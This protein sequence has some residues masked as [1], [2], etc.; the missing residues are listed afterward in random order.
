MAIGSVILIIVILVQI[1]KVSELAAKIRGEEESRIRSNRLNAAGMLAFVVVFLVGTVISAWAYRNWMLGYG[2]LESASEHGGLLDDLFSTTL[3]FTGIVFVLTHI[4][5]FYFAYK[6]REKKGRKVLFLPHDNRVEVIWTIIPAVVMCFLVVQGLVAWNT[7]MADVTD[8]V[9]DPVTNEIVQEG[10][11][12][13]EDYIEIE[14]TGYQFA[15][16]LRYPGNDNL[17][18]TSNFRLIDVANN[19]IGQDWTDPKGLDDFYPNEI[20]LPKGKKVRVRIKARDVLHNFYLPHFRVKMDAIPGLPT[21]FVFTPKY[22]TEEYR[23][24]LA[25]RDRND[26]VIYPEYWEFTDPDAPEDGMLWE[27]F[28]FELACAELCG[29]GHFSMHK[30]V[31]IV[32]EDEYEEWLATQKSHYIGSIR[33][34]DADPLKGQLLDYE[35][36]ERRQSFND[37]V[38]KARLAEVEADRIV[39]L[40]N[41]NFNTGSAEL[42]ADSRYELE[43]MLDVMQKYPQMRVEIAGHTDNTGNPDSNLTLS[44]N[45]AAAVYNYLT[46]EGVATN[47]LTYAGYGMTAPVETNDTEEGRLMN[48]R[49]EFKILEEEL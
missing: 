30:I 11:V 23:Q 5:L 33:G 39:R 12:I 25:A 29:K 37:A 2:P 48:R 14:A 1:G 42:T 21:Y 16:H 40:E 31:R 3:W 15:W 19:P 46:A 4:A 43:N 13:G 34:T 49:V 44:Q 26:E 36:R 10:D 24:L 20:V 32:E 7:V 9:V 8:E 18:G 27:N 6:Y 41:V 17:L 47:R 22:T 45:R 28:N 35:L 38:E